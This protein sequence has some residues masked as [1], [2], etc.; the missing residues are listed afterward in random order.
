[1]LLL[2]ARQGI[3]LD[4]LM[5]WEFRLES[6]L[7]ELN[8][9]RVRMGRS[10]ITWTEVARL[11][12]MSRQALQNLASNRELKVTNTRF[13]EAICRFFG[14]PIQEVVT[15]VP[16]LDTN[17]VDMNEV[18]PLVDLDRELRPNERPPFH[19]EELY[20]QRAKERWT[21]NRRRR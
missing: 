5:G 3:R 4:F 1:M 15:L 17:G 8:R 20:G 7:E 9:N 19:I 10:E 18:D 11:L 14:K 21:A 16:P 12:G 2:G 13:L 6:L